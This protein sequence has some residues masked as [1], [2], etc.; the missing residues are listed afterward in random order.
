MIFFLARP[1]ISRH[2]PDFFRSQSSLAPPILLI[3]PT[4]IT[5]SQAS[6]QKCF[7]LTY[8]GD[9]IL[10]NIFLLN[11]FISTFYFCLVYLS[12]LRSALYSHPFPICVTLLASQYNFFYINSLLKFLSHKTSILLLLS[13][14]LLVFCG[15]F[16]H[17][18]LHLAPL[19][20]SA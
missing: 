19:N 12:F 6:A 8:F 2:S 9:F 11:Y 7:L 5:Q 18:I 4:F 3:S 17:P 10:H 16:L 14:T 15:G 20:F 13:F 1:L